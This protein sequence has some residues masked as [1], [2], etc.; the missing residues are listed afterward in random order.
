VHTL[1]Q[2]LAAMKSLL[3]KILGGS[4]KIDLNLTVRELEVNVK[5]AG[6]MTVDLDT[7]TVEGRIIFCALKDLKRKPFTWTEISAKLDERAWHSGSGT[8]SP[9]LSR[10]TRKKLLIKEANGYRL[11]SLVTFRGADLE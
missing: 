9:A 5:H 1:E 6:L 7:T 10:L 4:G 11:P 3:Q 2:D 8:L